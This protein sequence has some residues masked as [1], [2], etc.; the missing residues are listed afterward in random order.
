MVVVI[1]VW[2]AVV[3]VKW[4]LSDIPSYLLKCKVSCF[5]SFP[6]VFREAA[7]AGAE[8]LYVSVYIE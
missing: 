1:A 3:T 2:M 8:D 4:P 5:S 7:A 6:D